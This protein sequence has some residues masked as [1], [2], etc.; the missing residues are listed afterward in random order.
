MEFSAVNRR[1]P[2][3]ETPVGPGAKKGGCFRKLCLP[4]VLQGVLFTFRRYDV[5]IGTIC[6]GRERESEYTAHVGRITKRADCIRIAFGLTKFITED[7]LK[8]I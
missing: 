8:A 5:D 7:D 1:R 3:R 4:L 2:S 6:R